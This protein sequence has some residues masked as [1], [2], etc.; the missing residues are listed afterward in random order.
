MRIQCVHRNLDSDKSQHTIMLL[1][2]VT[3]HN[4]NT[5]LFKNILQSWTISYMIDEDIFYF[6]KSQLI[7]PVKI[8]YSHPWYESTWMNSS[9][10]HFKLIILESS[11]LLLS[12]SRSWDS[13]HWKQSMRAHIPSCRVTALWLP[14]NNSGKLWDSWSR[15]ESSMGT[16]AVEGHSTEY[17]AGH[18]SAKQPWLAQVCPCHS[19]FFLACDQESLP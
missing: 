13:F 5:L 19:H 10:K 14:C 18:S 2:H 8:E 6:K 3:A 15:I 1:S 16:L 12:T 7:V 4:F 17:I 9:T 11:C